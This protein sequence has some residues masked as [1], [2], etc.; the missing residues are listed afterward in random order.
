MR[1]LL[2]RLPDIVAGRA[3]PKTPAEGC[4]FADLCG[5][6]FQNR[7]AAS[8]RLYDA[9]FTADPLLADDLL[10]NH[11]YNAACYAARAARGDG[12][13]ASTDAG[14][15]A[16][17]RAKALAWLRADLALGRKQAAS[18]SAAERKTA[19]DKLL[20]W[21][22]DS[23]LSRVRPGLGR[24]GMADAERADWDKFWAEVRATRDDAL[25]PPLRELKDN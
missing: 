19:A 4:E 11:R 13:D 12:V 17:L 20:H 25:K 8:A 3:A 7:F 24:I 15:R 22:G 23:D 16:V 5:Q 21:L 10:A 6:L 2:P 9:A 18:S 14:E 1:E